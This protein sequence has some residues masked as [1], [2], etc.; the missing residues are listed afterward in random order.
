MQQLSQN[1]IAMV[2]EHPEGFVRSVQSHGLLKIP[3]MLLRKGMINKV[4]DIFLY[5]F[6]NK[7]KFK[8]YI[9]IC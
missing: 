9:D 2:L 5:E 3:L 7:V 4:Y 8:K 6:K 1:G